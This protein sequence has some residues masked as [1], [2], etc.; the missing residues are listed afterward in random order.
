MKVDGPNPVRGPAPARPSRAASGSGFADVLGG[1]G[2]AA[3]ETRKASGPAPVGGLD[4][5]LAVQEV[6]DRAARRRQATR[7]GEAILD[8]LEGLRRDLLMG[9]VPKDRLLAI[10][11][12]VQNQRAQLDD[13]LLVAVLDEIDLRAQVE[14]AKLG[15]SP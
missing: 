13:P 9:V 4:A 5:L 7:R 1:T 11:R 15:L 14:L 8:Q 12:Q 10:A 6:D 2:G 3:A